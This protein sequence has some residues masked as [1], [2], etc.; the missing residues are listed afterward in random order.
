MDLINYLAA[1]NACCSC[2][3]SSADVYKTQ[4]SLQLTCQIQWHLATIAVLS[5]FGVSSMN[6]WERL[7]GS[8]VNSTMQSDTAA[9]QLH[10]LKIQVCEHVLQI[11]CSSER[12]H[13]S[14]PI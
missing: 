13:L 7:C 10:R 3:L 5:C 8:C 14:P 11:V 1:T 6:G 12:L 4:Q 2:S 9:C